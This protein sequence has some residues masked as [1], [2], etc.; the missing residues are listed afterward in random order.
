MAKFCTNC[1]KE[2]I[3]GKCNCVKAKDNSIST[4]DLVEKCKEVVVGLFKKPVTTI[5]ENA[6]SFNNNLKNVS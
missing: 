1:G 3:D 6:F 2:L 5:K 4:N